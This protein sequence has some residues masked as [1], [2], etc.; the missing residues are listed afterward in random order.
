MATETL[1]AET[2]ALRLQR[3]EDD[4]TWLWKEVLRL[5]EELVNAPYP[6]PAEG[7]CLT[8]EVVQLRAENRDLRDRL[9]RLRVCL[10]EELSHQVKLERA[11]RAAAAQEETRSAAAGAQVAGRG[12]SVRGGRGTAPPR[13][14]AASR[15]AKCMHSVFF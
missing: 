3:Q 7:P 8:R 1:T 14:R 6:Y 2:V 15:P 12:Y 13:P 4:I 11:T 10:A 9:Y 5:R